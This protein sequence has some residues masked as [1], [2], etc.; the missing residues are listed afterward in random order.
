MTASTTLFAHHKAYYATDVCMYYNR[1]FEFLPPPILI[2]LGE[3]FL[4]R[5]LLNLFAR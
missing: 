2:H 1:T 3:Y 4:E 5:T